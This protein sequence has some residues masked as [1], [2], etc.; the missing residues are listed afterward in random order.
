MSY[1]M[2]VPA[3][4]ET[5]SD[6]GALKLDDIDCISNINNNNNNNSNKHSNSTHFETRRVRVGNFVMSKDLQKKVCK[7]FVCRHFHKY[8]GEFLSSKNQTPLTDKREGDN[9][10]AKK[11]IGFVRPSRRN[12]RAARYVQQQKYKGS[13][14]THREKEKHKGV[15]FESVDPTEVDIRT[16]PKLN[17]KPRYPERRP[18]KKTVAGKTFHLTTSLRTI[19]RV[20]LLPFQGPTVEK[21]AKEFKEIALQR[22]LYTTPIQ[23]EEGL[24]R[25]ESPDEKLVTDHLQ[26]IQKQGT[27]GLVG[28]KDA[29]IEEKYAYESAL[30]YYQNKVDKDVAAVLSTTSLL[31]KQNDI[32]LAKN[33]LPGKGTDAKLATKSET[34]PRKTAIEEVHIIGRSSLPNDFGLLVDEDVFSLER[35]RAK[36][37]EKST[38]KLPGLQATWHDEEDYNGCI[39]SESGRHFVTPLDSITPSENVKSVRFDMEGN[40]AWSLDSLDNY[41][42][43]L[44]LDTASAKL[45]NRYEVPTTKECRLPI[46][47]QKIQ[48]NSLS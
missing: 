46:I 38:L 21:S 22:P 12:E 2:D 39:K 5:V 43:S 27:S 23:N 40:A 1:R 44:V 33:K 48:T 18:Y 41:E 42:T 14:G 20:D 24:E 47:G 36:K 3:V 9:F 11:V 28:G 31:A 17:S 29:N 19:K 16:L 13:E 35:S 8:S 32:Q 34:F 6:A 45:L 10:K 26:E 7:G 4:K 25:N 37:N 30:V 15:R